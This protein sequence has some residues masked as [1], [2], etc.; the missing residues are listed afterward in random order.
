MTDNPRFIS[1]NGVVD[2]FRLLR[3]TLREIQPQPTIQ[4]LVKAAGSRIVTQHTGIACPAMQNAQEFGPDYQGVKALCGV[5]WNTP[6]DGRVVLLFSP[7]K[8]PALPNYY[9]EW[10][11]ALVG[12]WA[13]DGF[14]ARLI[15]G[16]QKS[17][18]L[19]GVPTV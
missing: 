3:K 14:A 2:A 13:N 1:S 6:N 10:H 12:D 11:V 16:L 4:Q 17:L 7:S 8:N 15:K 18:E 19:E 5:R 9:G